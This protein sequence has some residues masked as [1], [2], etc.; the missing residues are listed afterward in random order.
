[1][2]N[3]MTVGAGKDVDVGRGSL[4]AYTGRV[5]RKR[6]VTSR[7]GSGGAWG[8]GAC[9]ALGWSGANPALPTLLPNPTP[10][11]CTLSL[12]L[13]GM[14]EESR[15]SEA[16]ARGCRGP[17]DR[18]LGPTCRTVTPPQGAINRAP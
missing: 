2:R 6:L 3:C 16:K 11:R 1:M 18:A 15:P 4:V 8:G 12:T 14:G 17:I 9:T 7:G 10:G 5:L 13:F